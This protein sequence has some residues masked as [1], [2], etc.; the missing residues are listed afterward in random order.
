MPPRSL[1]PVPLYDPST[2]GWCCY[3]VPLPQQPCENRERESSR[4]K[5]RR[6]HRHRTHIL[7]KNKE[8]ALKKEKEEQIKKE[9]EA[10]I[11]KE[12]EA[13]LKKEYEAKVK[14]EHQ[15]KQRKQKEKDQIR[16]FLSDLHA[17]T[18]DFQSRKATAWE[19]DVFYTILRGALDTPPPHECLPAIFQVGAEFVIQAYVRNILA[20]FTCRDGASQH[21]CLS[22]DQKD[23]LEGLHHDLICEILGHT[24]CLFLVPPGHSQSLPISTSQHPGVHDDY[25]P[26]LGSQHGR[27]LQTMETLFH[28]CSTSTA[29][30]RPAAWEMADFR[31][32]A[33]RMYQLV[34][35]MFSASYGEAFLTSLVSVAASKLRII[36]RFSR[37]T[38]SIVSDEPFPDD[39]PSYILPKRLPPGPNLSPVANTHCARSPFIVA[40][41]D[42][43]AR[44]PLLNARCH[45]SRGPSP[46][47]YTTELI[48]RCQDPKSPYRHLRSLVLDPTLL[49]VAAAPIHRQCPRRKAKWD[50]RVFLEYRAFGV[51]YSF[52]LG[53]A[54]KELRK[55]Q[56]GPSY[57][58]LASSPAAAKPMKNG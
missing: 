15:E 51:Y 58:W 32:Q 11:K 33:H 26:F 19:F 43:T 41:L 10:K 53:S 37:D 30:M 18:T 25:D 8:A 3:M 50:D 12:Y 47:L 35:T 24:P 55:V 56:T 44:G 16:I 42:D 4:K 22:P 45:Q 36:P 20:I 52:C 17:I 34:S 49:T 23:G 27:W 29:T 14:V 38:L 7:N 5:K 39:D 48:S 13:K 57:S 1:P 40:A 54:R 28:P 21:A 2:G 31:I 6:F 46:A 9:Y